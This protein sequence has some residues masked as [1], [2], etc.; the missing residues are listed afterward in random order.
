LGSVYV[1]DRSLSLKGPA[2]LTKTTADPSALYQIAVGYWTSTVLLSANELGVFGAVADGAETAEEV[3]SALRVNGRATT[4][5]LDACASLELLVKRGGR[6]HLAPLAEFLVPGRPG[7]LHRALHWLWQQYAHWGRL[8]DAVRSGAPVTRPELH[9][10]ADPE[11]TRAFVLA[12][13]DRALGVARGVVPFLDLSGC[14]SLLDVG[15]GPGTYAALLAEAYPALVVTVLDLPGI[16][17]V[18]R[19][20]LDG[21][22]A[23]ARIELHSGDATHGEY[24]CERYDAVLFSGVLHQMAPDTIRRM[25]AASHRALRPGGRALICDLM[26]DTT[27]TRPVFSA[28]FSLQMLLTS[29]EGAA[30]PVDDCQGWLL[31]AGFARAEAVRLPSPY[32]LIRAE[33]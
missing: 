3:A 16:C 32:T 30:F 29:Q 13:H 18:A 33:K 4:M 15:G 2:M 17:T 8:T 24:G 21:S 6:Y 27:R 7:S 19:E 10:G 31:E 25:L 9:L 23:A 26:L 22:P 14:Q 1:T 5:L 12:M 28:L 11:Q 20:L